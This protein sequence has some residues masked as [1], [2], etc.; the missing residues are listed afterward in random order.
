MTVRLADARVARL[1]TVRSDGF[2]HLVPCC[3]ALDGEVVYS[4]VDDVK[5]KSTMALRRL[6]H[7]RAN[8][9][10]SLL[11]DHYDDTDWSAL[12]WVRIDGRGRVVDDGPD[13]DRARALLAAKYPQ[14]A[15]A[16]G[17]G[18]VLVIAVDTWRGWP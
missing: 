13:H 9:A 5:P 15:A 18:A 3:F 8:P 16:P 6:D 7:V 4:A 2:P 1:A 10:V 11:V 14:Y 12:W 17:F